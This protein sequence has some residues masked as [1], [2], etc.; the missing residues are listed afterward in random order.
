MPDEIGLLLKS[1]LNY[2]PCRR[3]Y[4]GRPY[5]QW[6]EACPCKTQEEEKNAHVCSAWGSYIAFTF[7]VRLNICSVCTTSCQMFA[8][9]LHFQ[10]IGTSNTVVS[11]QWLE[12]YHVISFVNMNGRDALYL[13][14]A[15][16]FHIHVWFQV[17]SL[18]KIR[19]RTSIIFAVPLISTGLVE[20]C[21]RFTEISHCNIFFMSRYMS[22]RHMGGEEV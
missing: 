2:R 13:Y 21:R 3:R 9:I 10:L 7:L 16:F 12:T 15:R 1:M 5:K 4:I 17:Y 11:S 18:Y 20:V 14:D 8:F 19:R 22:W 6:A